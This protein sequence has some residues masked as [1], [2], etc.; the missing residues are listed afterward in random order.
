MPDAPRHAIFA[1]AAATFADVASWQRA[2]AD[3]FATPFHFFHFLSAS[4]SFRLFS[5]TLS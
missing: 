5:I 1:A 4:F 3:V 2:A